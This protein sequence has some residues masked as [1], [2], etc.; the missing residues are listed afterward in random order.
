MTTRGRRRT[1]SDEHYI[2]DLCDKVL[3]VKGCR[4]HHFDFL[5]GDIGP[6][7]G[8]GRRLPVDAYYQSLKL[9]IEY[10]ERQ[11]SEKVPHFDKRPTIS[12]MTRGEQRKKYDAMRETVLRENH[13][14][15]VKLDYSDFVH[16]GRK[17]LQRDDIA[18]DEAVLR[19]KLARFIVS[20]AKK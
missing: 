20:N 2:L 7:G 15:L 12:G 18:A 10:R 1:D 13:I 17:R 11:H 8:T 19:E 6:Q 16:D 5:R 3:G 14:E 4:Q 9:V